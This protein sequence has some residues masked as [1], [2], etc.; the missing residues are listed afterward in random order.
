MGCR[1]VCPL[2]VRDT[3]QL[4]EVVTRRLWQVSGE[5]SSLDCANAGPE[6]GDSVDGDATGS[7]ATSAS[8]NVN[9]FVICSSRSY[10]HT[11]LQM[12]FSVGYP[13]S[14]VP[15][16]TDLPYISRSSAVRHTLQ[17]LA[18]IQSSTYFTQY[19][20]GLPLFLWRFTFPSSVN[21]CQCL[22]SEITEFLL[23]KK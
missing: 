13:F 17:T 3:R 5:V 22:V 19:L 21:F 18:A 4:K 20:F 15:A 2:Q 10:H 14:D 8:Q 9:V 7:R 12:D 6:K 23:F 16:L 1:R 11:L